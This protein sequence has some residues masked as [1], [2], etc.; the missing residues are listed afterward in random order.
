MMVRPSPFSR[1]ASPSGLQSGVLSLKRKALVIALAFLSFST[2]STT[3]LWASW[4]VVAAQVEQDTESGLRQA[5][6][7]LAGIEEERKTF[8]AERATLSAEVRAQEAELDA[9]TKKFESLRAEEQRLSEELAAE[10]EE[11]KVL[12]G[13]VRSTAK[14]AEAS[15]RSDPISVEVPAR[16]ELVGQLAAAGRF[17]GLDDIRK[18]VDF[19]FDEM[20]RSGTTEVRQGNFIGPEGREQSGDILRVG[21]FSAYYRLGGKVGFL[22]YEEKGNRLVAVPVRPSWSL[23]EVPLKTGLKGMEKLCPWTCRA[24][25]SSA[26]SHAAAVSSIG[27]NPAA[28]WSGPFFWSVFWPW[29]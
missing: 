26:A 19:Y 25:R 5:Q 20:Q 7:T 11:V 27:S 8:L 3:R 17:P 29:V 10:T 2:L 28:R 4:D 12:E 16:L 18:F 21:P 13:A 6:E 9:L 24:G 23:S 22:R 15:F 1:S 14:D